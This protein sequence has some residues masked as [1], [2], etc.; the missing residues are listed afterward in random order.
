MNDINSKSGDNS[1]SYRGGDRDDNLSEGS[2][3]SDKDMNGGNYN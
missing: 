1:D 3:D 2:Y